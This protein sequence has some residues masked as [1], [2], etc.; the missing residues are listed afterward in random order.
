MC[1]V[2]SLVVDDAVVV[3]AVIVV[4]K[5]APPLLLSSIIICLFDLWLEA[6]DELE[7]DTNDDN[8]FLI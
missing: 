7:E 3:D 8:R 6:T 2:P 1:S 4:E 5:R